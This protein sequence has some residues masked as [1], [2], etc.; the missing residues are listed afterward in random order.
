M[1]KAGKIPPFHKCT[2]Q[3]MQCWFFKLTNGISSVVFNRI[4]M[5]FQ[6]DPGGFFIDN[7]FVFIMDKGTIKTGRTQDLDWFF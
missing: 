5:V 1:K 3:I 6:K 4:W 7:G 2:I